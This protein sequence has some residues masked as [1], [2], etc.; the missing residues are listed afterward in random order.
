[1]EDSQSKIVSILSNFRPKDSV[2]RLV[3]IFVL[4]NYLVVKWKKNHPGLGIL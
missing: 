1:M 4:L 2:N 3:N